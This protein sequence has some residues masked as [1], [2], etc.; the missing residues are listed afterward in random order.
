MSETIAARAKALG[1]LEKAVRSLEDAGLYSEAQALFAAGAPL[2]ALIYRYEPDQLHG[3]S[4]V[5]AE[6]EAVS[7]S[8]EK[9]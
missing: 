1:H 6:R 5:M 8:K 7:Q 3:R 9:Q 4:R 2:R